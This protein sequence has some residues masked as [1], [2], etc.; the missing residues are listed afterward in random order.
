MTTG[1]FWS[2]KRVLV[3]G[4]TGFKGSWLSLWLADMGAQVYGLALAPEGTPALFN[5]L[6]LATRMDHAELDLRDAGGVFARIDEIRP[7]VVFH[8][9][10]QPLVRRSYAQPVET[11]ATNVQG[12]VHVLEALRKMQRPCTI[13]ISTTDKVYHNRE[14]AHC[15]RESDR[16][17]G[18]DPYS[19]S[20]AAT[21]LLIASYREALFAGSEIRVASA[22][23][24][25]VIGGGDWAEDRI[26][27]D[28]IRGLQSGAPVQV[29]NPHATR[30]WQHVLE[31]LSG[32]LDYAEQLHEGTAPPASL[33]F[34]PDTHANRPVRELLDLALTHW[35]GKW[36]DV[37]HDEHVHEA[38]RL[39]LSI[40][41]AR[42]SLGWLPRWSFEDAVAYTIDWYRAVTGGVDPVA[43]SRAQ[44][45]AYEAAR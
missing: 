38:D 2:G 23:A 42:V 45:A 43:T 36:E 9:A 21:E 41:L 11:W 32:Y 18:H 7:S 30:P 44:I 39:A 22:R 16:L 28:I 3:T 25:N 4:H 19:A 10:A 31:P 24:G 6:N 20:K 33:N 27:P 34:G 40:E 17:G 14:W 8:L 1:N 13:I 29:R 26:V 12:T 35:P 37:S 5:Q 15:Y